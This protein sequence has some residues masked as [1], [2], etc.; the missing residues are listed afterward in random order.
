[1]SP[2][3]ARVRGDGIGQ[4]VLD[5]VGPIVLE[6]NMGKVVGNELRDRTTHGTENML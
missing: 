3:E 2:V 4:G 5:A 1:M 6:L